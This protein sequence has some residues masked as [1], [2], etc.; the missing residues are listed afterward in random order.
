MPSRLGLR[1]GGNDLDIVV[2]Q[3][4]QFVER[5]ATLGPRGGGAHGRWF[6]SRLESRVTASGK[7]SEARPTVTGRAY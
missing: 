4:G 6:Q 1:R 2:E 3:I 7:Y 5:H